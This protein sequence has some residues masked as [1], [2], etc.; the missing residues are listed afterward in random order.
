M[1]FV[2]VYV[3]DIV[4][5]HFDNGGFGSPVRRKFVAH[6]LP[7][8]HTYV[9]SFSIPRNP[10][11]LEIFNANRDKLNILFEGKSIN[12]VHPEA[13]EG[14]FKNDHRYPLRCVNFVFEVQDNG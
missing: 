6:K 7:S 10:K 14:D 2:E 13:D 1:A 8:E 9:C 4:K 3:K 5:T 11:E 12:L